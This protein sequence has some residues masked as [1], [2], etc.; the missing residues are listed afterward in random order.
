VKMIDRSTRQTVV[1]SNE[2]PLNQ[3]STVRRILVADDDK[4][5]R[6]L[7]AGVLSRSGYHVVE[8]E[9]GEEGWE[10]LRTHHFDLL[11]TDNDMPRLT[12]VEL[13]KKIH[14]ARMTVLI[15]LA[16]GV[17]PVE[18]LKRHPWLQI[19]ATLLKP[20]TVEEL[21]ETVKKVLHSIDGSKY[22]IS[23]SSE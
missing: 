4:A 6:R 10:A 22:Q 7:S 20:F 18:E 14:T 1:Q 8:V 5:M 19:S 12:G 9:D 17:P 3:T 2:S 16:S 13:V 11:I 23:S 21:L 15:I